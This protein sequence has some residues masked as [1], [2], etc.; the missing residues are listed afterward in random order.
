MKYAWKTVIR[1]WRITLAAVLAVTALTFFLSVFTGS[2]QSSREQLERIYEVT[3]VTARVAGYNAGVDAVIKE[4]LYRAV[5]DSG[6]VKKYCSLIQLKTQRQE[7]LRKLNCWSYYK[8][9]YKEVD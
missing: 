2:I 7:L 5:L 9:K 6:F 1:N 3:T 4:D 8:L